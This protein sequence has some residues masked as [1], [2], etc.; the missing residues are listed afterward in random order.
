MKHY[1]GSALDP[2]GTDRFVIAHIVNDKHAWGAGFVVPLAK[3]FPASRQAYLGLHEHIR[4][5][6][7][8]VGVS[9][10]YRVGCVV[11][12]C[13]Q[14]L[15]VKHPLDYEALKLCIGHTQRF[16]LNAGASVHIPRIGCGLAGGDWTRI[17]RMIPESWNVY[18]LERERDLFPPENYLDAHP[19]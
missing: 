14:T 13:A 11:N 12:M 19:F 15:G 17:V 7:Q 3:K 1:I 6:I 8:I 4:G 16:A 10:D 9:I 2:V 5:L 18:T